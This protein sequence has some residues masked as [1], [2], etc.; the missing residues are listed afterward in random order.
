MKGVTL[1]VTRSLATRLIT[2]NNGSTQES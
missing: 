1:R 2:R